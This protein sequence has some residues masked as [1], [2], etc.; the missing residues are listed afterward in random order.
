MWTGQAQVQVQVQAAGGPLMISEFHAASVAPNI[1]KLQVP[2]SL[3][4]YV[5]LASARYE[6]YKLLQVRRGE[7]QGKEERK[8]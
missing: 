4:L 5:P 2:S 7:D 3:S 1:D 8:V 6:D